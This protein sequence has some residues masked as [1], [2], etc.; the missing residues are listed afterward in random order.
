MPGYTSGRGG[1]GGAGIGAGRGGVG[2]GGVGDNRGRGFGMSRP[3]GDRPQTGEYRIS[4]YGGYGYIGGYG[5]GDGDPNRG[6]WG[7]EEGGSRGT[8]RQ[9]TQHP[10][11]R[12]TTRSTTK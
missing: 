8:P 9:F 12:I 6:N 10:H 5:G 3:Y 1:L 7:G 4:R 2:R 11:N